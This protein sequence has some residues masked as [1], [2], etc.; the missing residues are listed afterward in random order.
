MIV[1]L[2]KL[3]NTSLLELLTKKIPSYTKRQVQ[4]AK[5]MLFGHIPNSIHWK[6][7][8]YAYNQIKRKYLSNSYDISTL[9]P[10]NNP[11]S[12]SKNIWVYWNSGMDSAPEL[13]VKC[14]KQLK[15]T[16]PDGYKLHIITAQNLYEYVHF[17]D[18]ILNKTKDGIIGQAHFSDLL[19]TALLYLYGGIW[20]DATCLLTQPIPQY[21]LH[22]DLFMFQANLLPLTETYP[23]IKCSNWFIAAR[24]PKNHILYRMLQVLLGYWSKKKTL[25]HYYLYH[26]ALSAL[27]ETEED[28]ASLWNKIPYVCNMNPHVMWFKFFEEYT[29]ER[30]NN[31]VN[32][33]FVHK[34]SYKFDSNELNRDRQ[35]LLMYFVNSYENDNE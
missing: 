34:L 10:K 2:K 13:V 24:T 1:I 11:C 8:W 4:K 14:N 3:R 29:P 5:W 21:V 18:F 9:Y 22:A 30:W 27:V 20:M 32:S 28:C 33:C 7:Q 15:K 12:D 25:I 6:G 17:P 19:R 31:A 23:P 35:N 26:L 16:I